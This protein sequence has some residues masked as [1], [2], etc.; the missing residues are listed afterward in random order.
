MQHT[1]E[2]LSEQLKRFMPFRACLCGAECPHLKVYNSD[3]PFCLVCPNCG[4]S[5]GPFADIQPAVTDWHRSNRPG[6]THISE[7]WAMRYESQISN[8]VQML[9][10]A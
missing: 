5:C 7:V 3:R 4:F 9:E 2:E 8:S 6:D 1:R 10:S